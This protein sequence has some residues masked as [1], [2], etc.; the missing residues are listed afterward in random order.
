MFWKDLIKK[1]IIPPARGFPH[2]VR[3]LQLSPFPRWA[4]PQLSVGMAAPSWLDI[5]N[6]HC[7]LP[8]FLCTC[9]GA[10]L[11]CSLHV[12]PVHWLGHL[13]HPSCLSPSK[14]SHARQRPGVSLRR[15]QAAPR[16]PSFSAGACCSSGCPL[17][18]RHGSTEPTGL[19]HGCLGAPCRASWC[20]AAAGH[21]A[22]AVVGL[23]ARAIEVLAPH[24][25]GQKRWGMQDD[26]PC[27]GPPSPCVGCKVGLSTA[28][29]P[30]ATGCTGGTDF[31]KEER[32]HAELCR[33]SQTLTAVIVE[34]VHSAFLMGKHRWWQLSAKC[35]Y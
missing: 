21:R 11:G 25:S 26:A 33:A 32:R 35:I 12:G 29:A 17:D 5:S 14:V 19:G 22:G 3:F 18:T 15:G 10:A 9:F 7:L 31:P 8:S 28:S 24:V 1:V 13:E 20:R 30:A 2:P 6:P 23:L 34:L 16:S 4:A 27:L